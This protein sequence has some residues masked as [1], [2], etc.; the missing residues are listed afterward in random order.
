MKLSIPQYAKT[1]GIS[2]VAAYKRVKTGKVKVDA[3]GK[4]DVDQAAVDWEANRDAR[5]G[6]KNPSGV[7]AE[8]R[9]PE[10]QHQRTSRRST[11]TTGSLSDA[12]RA[13][14]WLRVEREK[15]ALE[16]IEGSTVELAPI[17]AWAAGMI[18]KARE[19]LTRIPVELRDTIARETDPV[20]CE[21]MMA[22][23]IGRALM[24]LAEYRA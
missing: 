17:N 18:L 12:Q 1:V 3:D 13:R 20:A 4:V 21:Q 24:E 23:R 8:K 7:S 5:Q 15:L 16:A 11:D 14:E 2:K 19:E 10:Q 6:A 9:N 22:K